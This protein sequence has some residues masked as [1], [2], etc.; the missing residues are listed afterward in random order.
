M[1]PLKP[2]NTLV[3]K[4]PYHSSAERAEAIK[5]KQAQWHKRIKRLAESSTDNYNGSTVRVTTTTVAQE[6]TDKTYQVEARFNP[7]NGVA[8]ISVDKDMVF[9]KREGPITLTKHS[10]YYSEQAGMLPWD[11][12]VE[13]MDDLLQATEEAAGLAEPGEQPSE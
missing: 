4:L 8:A 1:P 7:N 5:E 10:P 3:E 2:G 9:S 11:L 6:G 13:Y 12:C